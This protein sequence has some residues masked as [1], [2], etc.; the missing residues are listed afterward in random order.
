MSSSQARYKIGDKA[1]MTKIF[2]DADIIKYAQASGDSNPIHCDGDYA[3]ITGFKGGI[4]HGILVA[5][6]ISAV[7]GTKLPGMGTIYVSQNL[8]F[9]KPV[10]INDS[11]T[12]RVEIT[13]ID[14]NKKRLTLSTYCFTGDGNLVSTGEAVV[15][16]PN[17]LL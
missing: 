8:K 7:L 11:V 4:V 1:E 16:P 5:G 17:K 6:L 10:F 3:V 15:I 2:S 14:E 13:N 12:A 9:I